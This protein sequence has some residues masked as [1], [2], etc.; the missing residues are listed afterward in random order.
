MLA[1]ILAIFNSMPLNSAQDIITNAFILVF[2]AI[3]L[4]FGLAFG[5][6]GKEFAADVLKKLK[7]KKEAK[8]KL[9]AFFAR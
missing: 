5:L 3:C 7:T 1:V 6:G 8:Q 4:A 2:G 9:L